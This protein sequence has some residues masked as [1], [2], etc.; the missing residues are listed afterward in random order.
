M[1]SLNVPIACSLEAGSLKERLASI[2]ALNA[3]ALQAA[4]REDLTLI[5]DY[6]RA[7]ADEVQRMVDA[8]KSCCA[9]L[10]FDLKDVGDQLRLTIIAP[11]QAREAAEMLFEPF[12]SRKITSGAL[13]CGCNG[14]CRE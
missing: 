3:R 6:D 13:G 4:R 2:A 12:A 14:G 11:P 1:S 10:A 9:F 8:E 5:L 7:A